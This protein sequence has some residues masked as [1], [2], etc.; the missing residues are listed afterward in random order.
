[1]QRPLINAFSNLKKIKLNS[2]M[3]LKTLIKWILGQ[4]S[5][6]LFKFYNVIIKYHDLRNK[7][8]ASELARSL[9]EEIEILSHYKDS[10][11]PE[12]KDRFDNVA[13]LLTSIEEFSQRN[14]R[15]GLSTFLEDVSLQTD[16]DHWNDSDN[17][18]TLMTVHSS[19]GLEFP[20]VF[21]AG[22][23]EGLF[24]LF[25]SLDDKSELEEERRLFYVALTRAEQKVY[26]LYATN[27]K[28][29]GAET[30]NGLPSRF[31]NEIPEESLDRIS[32]SSAC[33]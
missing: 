17:R 28:E 30:V 29:N 25:R 9:V 7:L 3:F 16:I 22:M 10:K 8:S 13:E 1:M 24:P 2:L 11:E 12:A 14:P 27:R 19:K 26:L 20:V 4:T 15:S 32:F 6:A 31:I 33:N 18:V 21:I 23:D 5:D